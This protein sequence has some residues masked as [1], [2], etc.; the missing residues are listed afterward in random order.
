MSH[1]VLLGLVA[2]FAVNVARR[3]PG[4]ADW[5][6]NG[7][8]PWACDVCMSFWVVAAISGIRYGVHRHF[9]IWDAVATAGVCLLL[10]ILSAPRPAPLPPPPDRP[11][12]F[13]DETGAE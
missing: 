6:L 8:K 3:L 13:P 4:V 9:D 2:F 12:I 11:K 7:I 5:T 10:L 1:V